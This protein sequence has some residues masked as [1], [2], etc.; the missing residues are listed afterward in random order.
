[1]KQVLPDQIHAVW[2]LVKSYLLRLK[3]LQPDTWLP[4][5][6]YSEVKAGKAVL[7]MTDGGCCVVQP[8]KDP[9]NAE[10]YL[11]VWIAY[12]E[13]FG[14]ID[15]YLPELE[16]IALNAGYKRLTLRSKR[17]GFARAGFEE[18]TTMFERRL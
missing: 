14:A 9:W 13:K 7:Y 2:P 8:G 1:M 4:E 11:H 3:E 6:V 12:S 17:K 16:K 5:D 15:Q 18:C 10:P